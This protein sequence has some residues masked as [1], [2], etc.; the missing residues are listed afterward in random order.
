MS[1]TGRSPF[2]DFAVFA[3]EVFVLIAR[4]IAE[5]SDWET[6]VDAAREELAAARMPVAQ[7]LR[8]ELGLRVIEFQFAMADPEPVNLI[9]DTHF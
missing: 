9:I 3:G 1:Q 2:E 5:N 6:R 7:V 4:L 8:H